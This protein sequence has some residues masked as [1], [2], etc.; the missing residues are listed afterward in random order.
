MSPWVQDFIKCFLQ[1]KHYYLVLQS[2]ILKHTKKLRIR[3]YSEEKQKH[4]VRTGSWSPKLSSARFSQGSL[5]L[6]LSPTLCVRVDFLEGLPW[7]S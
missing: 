6:S 1:Q 7:S 2:I 4:T 5:I 3:F